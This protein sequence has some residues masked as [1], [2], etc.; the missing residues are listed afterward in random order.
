MNFTYQ[1]IFPI[2]CIRTFLHA[3]VVTKLHT[4]S[5]ETDSAAK[6]N[7]VCVGESLVRYINNEI[8]RYGK[9]QVAVCGSIQDQV[10]T[11]RLFVDKSTQLENFVVFRKTWSM[12]AYNECHI[13]NEINIVLKEPLPWYAP[14]RHAFFRYS[15]TQRSCTL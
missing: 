11:T 3:N 10:G 2:T 15:L 9:S 7:S 1:S 6:K 4:V 12:H 13:F 5:G 8:L 14:R